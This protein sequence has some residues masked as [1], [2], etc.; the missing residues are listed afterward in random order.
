M[1]LLP[2]DVMAWGGRGPLN[3]LLFGTVAFISGY[4]Q[5]FVIGRAVAEGILAVS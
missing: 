3:N 4:V 5:W 2:D 1:I